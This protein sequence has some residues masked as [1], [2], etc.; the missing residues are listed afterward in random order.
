MVQAKATSPS[1]R[2]LHLCPLNVFTFT[3]RPGDSVSHSCVY[4]G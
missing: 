2:T 1:T 4:E 3:A